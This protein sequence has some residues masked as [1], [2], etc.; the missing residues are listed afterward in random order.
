[1]A[2][3]DFSLLFIQPNQI[4]VVKQANKETVQEKEPHTLLFAPIYY[5]FS[6]IIPLFIFL[7]QIKKLEELL[8]EV[9][10]RRNEKLIQVFDPLPPAA[11]PP[12]P[13]LL[14]KLF[15]FHFNLL[16]M[17]THNTFVS[18]LLIRRLNVSIRSWV[19][20]TREC[21]W[22]TVV[23]TCYL[24]HKQCIAQWEWPP[25][26]CFRWQIL[27]TGREPWSEPL[28]GKAKLYG[29]C[30]R[31]PC[32]PWLWPWECWKNNQEPVVLMKKKNNSILWT[33]RWNTINCNSLVKLLAHFIKHL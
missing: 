28:C 30:K 18:V 13:S 4:K 5:C 23:S 19:F 14:H 6:D 31:Q 25:P 32:H 7:P 16:L 24:F 11:H 1:M 27:V 2:H 9:K 33:G 12:L 10:L 3:L 21:R 15:M 26:H 29:C 17:V 20:F 8:P 22:V